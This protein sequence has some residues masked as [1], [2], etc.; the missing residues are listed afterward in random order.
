MLW[1]CPKLPHSIPTAAHKLKDIIKHLLWLLRTG[2]WNSHC[3]PHFKKRKK[4]GFEWQ[5]PR[6]SLFNY[7]TPYLHSH[8]S[9]FPHL[10]LLLLTLH[11]LLPPIPDT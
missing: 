9:G 5:D 8:P 6:L 2:L 1:D 3:S 7:K 10:L 4:S 11:E